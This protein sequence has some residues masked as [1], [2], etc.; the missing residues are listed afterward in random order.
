LQQ[1][2]VAAQKARPGD[3]L[4]VY[5]AGHGVAVRDLYIYPT[6]EARTLDEF[7]DAAIRDATGISS[8]EL[9][10]WIKKIPASHQL[11]ILDTCA[12]GAAARKLVEPRDVPSDQIRAL[13]MLNGR[14]GFHVLMGSAADAVSYEASQYG[15]GLLTY[16]LLQG[17]RG[18]ALKND[19]EADVTTLFQ[20][21]AD[22]VP[23]LAREIG[24]IQ[25]PQILLGAGGS[26]DFGILEKEDKERIPLA[27][28][29]PII[30][31]PVFLNALLL[32][33]DLGLSAVLRKRLRE[34][35]YASERGGRRT[36]AA[37]FVDESESPGA[38]SPSGSYTIE[39]RK[40]NVT[41]VLSRDDREV[42]RFT[43]DGSSDDLDALA[44]KIVQT[45]LDASIDSTK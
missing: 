23:E 45:I 43:I 32:R 19:V 7:S 6:Q 15:Q 21:A 30:L 12:A 2:F 42:Y 18:A 33:D 10:D 16:S 28:S 36:A 37:I 5:L 3:V 8:E 31:R 35:T 34:E 24:G 39:G 13:D 22:R 26:F 40:V 41:V 20:F 29:K 44:A 14:T 9:V 25:R 1:A 17:M 11:M 27:A 38:I 4:V